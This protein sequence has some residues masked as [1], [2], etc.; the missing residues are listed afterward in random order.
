MPYF[1]TPPPDNPP[2]H[3]FKPRN[4]FYTDKSTGLCKEKE[5]YLALLEAAGNDYAV[6]PKVRMGDILYNENDADYSRISSKHVD[7][8]ICNKPNFEV[9]CVVEL[10]GPYHGDPTTK[11]RD[12]AKSFYLKDANIPIL[13]FPTSW[14][15]FFPTTIRKKIDAAKIDA[16]LSYPARVTHKSNTVANPEP[17]TST[18][19]NTVADPRPTTS[20]KTPVSSSRDQPAREKSGCLNCMATAV[21]I[22]LILYAIYHYIIRYI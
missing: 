12:Q 5:L 8:L 21:I 14:D 1:G 17:A 15:K 19:S 20:T 6:F 3:R 4:I 2:T 22:A 9:K 18:K 10:D 13:R 7:F 16:T 11:L